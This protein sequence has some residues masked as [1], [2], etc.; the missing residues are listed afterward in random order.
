MLRY[1]GSLLPSVVADYLV[2]V[3]LTRLLGEKFSAF[4][5]GRLVGFLIFYAL[6]ARNIGERRLMH[7]FAFLLLFLANILATW[8]LEKMDILAANFLVYKFTLDAS[9]FLCNFGFFRL[10][11][12]RRIGAMG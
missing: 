3:V 10:V 2:Y 5:I 8:L 4:V 9:L 11:Q 12:A 1:F 6:A 7:F